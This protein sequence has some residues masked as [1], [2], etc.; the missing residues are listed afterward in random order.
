MFDYRKNRTTI[1]PIGFDWFLVRFLS[2]SYPGL[3]IW[4]SRCMRRR[5]RR[6]TEDWRML[7]KRGT[8]SGERGM[9][10]ASLGA[11]CQRK[12]P[13]KSKMAVQKTR[14]RKTVLTVFLSL[15]FF[16]INQHSFVL[17]SV[18]FHSWKQ[19]LGSVSRPAI[20]SPR[21]KRLHASSLRK[22]GRVQKRG[23]KREGEGREGKSFP[24]VLLLQSSI[25]FILA[26]N[27]VQ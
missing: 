6:F 10:N 16:S 26:P 4:T 24:L 17:I 2:I 23:M 8:G 13:Q 22:L 15:F 9:G 20:S 25:S 5:T 11:S 3:K 21:S 14:E 19:I 27:F 12:P 1:R 18:C 7:L